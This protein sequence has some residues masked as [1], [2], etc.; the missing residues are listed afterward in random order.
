M[1]VTTYSFQDNN[2]SFNHPFGNASSSGAGIGTI[3]VAMTQTKTTHDVA[4]DGSVMISKIEGDNGTIAITIQ[5]TSQLHK[6]LKNWYNYINTSTDT[7]QWASMA[8]NINNK[9]LGDSVV[10]TNVS[11]QKL[12]DQPYQAQGQMVTWT[13]MAVKITMK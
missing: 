9:S 12:P 7:S 1:S 4:A 11:P 2:V 6:Y 5:Q 3:S 10:A 8:I 13:L